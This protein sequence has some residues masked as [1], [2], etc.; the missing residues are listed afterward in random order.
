MSFFFSSSLICVCVA[1]EVTHRYSIQST[2]PS[3]LIYFAIELIPPGKAL[4]G[5]KNPQNPYFLYGPINSVEF[6]FAFT[7]FFFCLSH[8]FIPS[9]FFSCRCASSTNFSTFI[10]LFSFK[11]PILIYNIPIGKSF[12]NIIFRQILCDICIKM[13]H[14]I[15]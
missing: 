5:K 6:P 12:R 2:P 10:S 3:S 15:V 9:N 13:F 14:M 7:W 11:S 4:I 8:F 1:L